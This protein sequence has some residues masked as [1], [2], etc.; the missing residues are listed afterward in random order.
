MA[1]AYAAGS[2]C[3]IGGA[4]FFPSGACAW[5]SL[6]L[7]SADF[8]ALKIPMNEDLQKD[9]SALETLAQIA[10]VYI[11]VHSFPGS[12]IPIRIPTLSDNTGAEAVSNKLLT[13]QIP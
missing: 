2:K 13:T 1:D 11:A 4:L 3:G 8:Q 6:Q 5:F 9:I 12:R 7:V 10:L